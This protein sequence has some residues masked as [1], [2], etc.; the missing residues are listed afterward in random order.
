LTSAAMHL[1]EILCIICELSA[2]C[3]MPL[4]SLLKLLFL[5]ILCEMRAGYYMLRRFVLWHWRYISFRV[6]CGI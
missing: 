2:G 4:C 3:Y 5:Y 1:V 6:K